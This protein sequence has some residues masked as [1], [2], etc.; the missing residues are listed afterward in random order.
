MEKIYKTITTQE[1]VVELMNYIKEG[2]IIAYD[3]ET[4]SVNPRTGDIIGFSVSCNL[5]E[6]YYFPTKSGM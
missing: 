2:N 5:N 3:T 6:G 1:G 4:T